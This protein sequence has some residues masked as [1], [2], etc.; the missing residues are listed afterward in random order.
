MKSA[1]TGS[2][3]AKPAPPRK[4]QMRR[5]SAPSAATEGSPD[6]VAREQRVREAAYFI[7]ERSGRADGCALEN[8]LAAEAMLLLEEAQAM[9][10]EASGD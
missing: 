8:W 7:Y 4:P 2:I 9:Q 3:V 10:R 6:P 1:A 5:V